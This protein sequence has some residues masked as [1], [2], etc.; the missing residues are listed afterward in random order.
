MK[1]GLK[2]LALILAIAVYY[3]LKSGLSDTTKNHDQQRFFEHR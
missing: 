3:A 2:L 1:I